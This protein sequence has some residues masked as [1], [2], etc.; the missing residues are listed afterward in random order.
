MS[1]FQ[2]LIRRTGVLST[3]GAQVGAFVKAMP[4]AP[5]P[6]TELQIAPYSIDPASNEIERWPGLVCNV[7]SLRPDSQGS[8]L[9]RS[10]D[11]AVPPAKRGNFLSAEYD[12]QLTVHMVRYAS[13]LL[14]AA[15]SEVSRRRNVSRLCLLVSGR[16]RRCMSP[17]RIAG[18]PLFRDLPDGA[19]CDGSGRPN[20]PCSRRLGITGRRLL[21]HANPCIWQY[22]W[23]SH[24]N[25]M[26]SSRPDSGRIYLA[27]KLSRVALSVS[28]QI[29]GAPV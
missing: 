7:Q 17:L 13:A 18:L 21:D 9:I 26:A 23:T 25:R 5:R 28:C 19:R 27:V 11:S 15:S 10:A 29:L 4:D 3:A 20:A 24:G 6:D 22:Q 12:R 8:V 16:D 1:A 14:S 2:Y